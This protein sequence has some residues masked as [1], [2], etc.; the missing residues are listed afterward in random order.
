MFF[1]LLPQYASI[2]FCVFCCAHLFWFLH[3]SLTHCT[4]LIWHEINTLS[5]AA[6]VMESADCGKPSH[7]VLFW[8]YVLFGIL[9]NSREKHNH[10]YMINL[11]LLHA[12]FHTHKCKFSSKKTLFIF[13]W[14]E[15]ELVID[16][17]RFSMKQ[18][19][20]KT[21]KVRKRFN[22]FIEICISIQPL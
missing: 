2:T 5:V 13:F 6:S 22:I 3:E 19:A 4:S 10:V 12:R 11:I 18:K 20:I 1:F 21:V 9:E 16:T 17:I 8:K 15:M 7:F 14:K